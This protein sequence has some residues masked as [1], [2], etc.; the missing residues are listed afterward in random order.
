MALSPQKFR[1]IVFQLLYS[2]DF[3][4]G[5]ED[6]MID[7]MMEQLAVTKK[8]MKEAQEKHQEVVSRIPEIDE[9][10]RRFSVSYNL[11]RIG[12]VEKSILRLGVYE[13][14]YQEIVPA[15]VAI[16]E[17]IRLTRKFSTPESGSFINAVLDS[18]LQDRLSPGTED[19]DLTTISAS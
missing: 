17:A 9:H 8:S 5:E 14:C 10:I 1:E 6:D 3:V 4:L 18:I 11:E 16:A 2:H 15:K 19:H 12:R 13:I 7:F